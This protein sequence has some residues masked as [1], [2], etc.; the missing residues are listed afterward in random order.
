MTPYKGY[1]TKVNHRMGE[2]KKLLIKEN[3]KI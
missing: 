1:M 2:E 3:M